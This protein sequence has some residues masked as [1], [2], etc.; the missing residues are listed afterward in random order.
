MKVNKFFIGYF[1][2]LLILLSGTQKGWQT[3]ITFTDGDEILFNEGKKVEI[4][5]VDIPAPKNPERSFQYFGQI[6]N[7]RGFVQDELWLRIE[8]EYFI[9][10]YKNGKISDA[11]LILEYCRFAR[12][13]TK[14]A[15]PHDLSFKINV[16]LHE[17]K[18]GLS[19]GMTLAKV[20]GDYAEIHL[21]TPSDV[22]D[23]YKR[24]IDN[25]WYQKNIVHEY[26]HVPTYQN[27][28]KTRWGNK[29]GFPPFF[30][31]AEYIAIFHTTEQILNKYS[32]I[33]KDMENTIIRNGSLF[34]PDYDSYRWG[35]YLAKYMYEF[36]GKESIYNLFHTDVEYFWDA[37]NIAFGVS[38]REF[39]I[40][41]I[42]WIYDEFGYALPSK[43][44]T[45][46][47]EI[48]VTKGGTTSPLPGTHPY[49]PETPALIIAR[50]DVHYL[51]NGWTGDV[52]SSKN[53]LTIIM[54]SDKTI[55][56]NF[57]RKIYPPLN[58]FG[59]KKENRSVL[60][61]EYINVLTWQANQDNENI[62]QYRIYQMK[63]DD[64][65]LLVELDSG[66]FEYWHRKVKKEKPYTYVLVAVA[67]GDR[68]G[69]PVYLTI[70]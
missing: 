5:R 37:L 35:T 7:Q 62:Q 2:I 63:G 70:Q 11:V 52:S 64:K 51:F 53:P 24:W 19:P 3:S 65:N 1:F 54:D 21:L 9:I 18:S 39:E 15:Y 57:I 43:Y 27:I 59:V 34:F 22:P 40:N 44:Q 48:S 50:P 56:A 17:I 41:W 60:L 30:D 69:Q 47:I 16:Y 26:V 14:K 68:E 28:W 55:T 61:I 36:Y 42:K 13:V 29:Y 66:T 32:K 6:N 25:I 10:N 38:P 33:I 49:L 23:D 20:W 12:N 45:Y 4:I 8:D 67:A 58:F 31:I 46:S